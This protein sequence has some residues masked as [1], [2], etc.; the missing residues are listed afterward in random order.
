MSKLGQRMAKFVTTEQ[1]TALLRMELRR[2][3][4]Y[5]ARPHSSGRRQSLVTRLLFLKF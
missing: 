4:Q 3:P 2:F 1:G 5:L